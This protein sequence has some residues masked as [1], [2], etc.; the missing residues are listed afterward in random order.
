[1][2]ASST[3]NMPPQ[4][5]NRM[6]LDPANLYLPPNSSTPVN[7]NI[8]NIGN[9]AGSFDLS[10]H[11]LPLTTTIGSLPAAQA[12]AQ[13]ASAS[14]PLSLTIGDAAGRDVPAGHRGQ[15]HQQHHAVCHGECAWPGHTA[16]GFSS[17]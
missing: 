5:F 8:T 17:G 10:A 12:L 15:G 2:Q 13:G 11:A 16:A 6:T 3:F 7:L 14:L 9:A 4:P 1:V